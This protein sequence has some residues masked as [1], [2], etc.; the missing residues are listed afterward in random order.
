[1]KGYVVSYSE[2]FEF[3]EEQSRQLKEKAAAVKSALGKST[4]QM[5]EA[6]QIVRWAF[7]NYKNKTLERFL[8]LAGI[9]RSVGNRLRKF[10]KCEELYQPGTK[11]V[12]VSLG[13]SL[14]N[15]LQKLS[16]SPKRFQEAIAMAKEGTLTKKKLIA[17]VKQQKGRPSSSRTVI[18]KVDMDTSKFDAL[19]LSDR[20]DLDRSCD[21]ADDI[22]K[23]APVQL[24]IKRQEK[25]MGDGP[26]ERAPTSSSVH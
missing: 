5:M 12:A 22:F 3:N 18:Y 16:S 24:N 11:E 8:T 15:E 1:M 10:A 26:T 6:A 17:M 2:S 21:H 20:K 25:V 13:W 7:D 9:S 4:E 19:S 23:D 14:L